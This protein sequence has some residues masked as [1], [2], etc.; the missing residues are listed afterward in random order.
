MRLGVK[1]LGLF[2]AIFSVTSYAANNN[3]VTIE[4]K[5]LVGVAESYGANVMLAPSVEFPTV[6]PAYALELGNA[7]KRNNPESFTKQFDGY[8]DPTRCY[9]YNNQG[10]YFE[11]AGQAHSFSYGG[12]TLQG[13]CYKEEWINGQRKSQYFSGSFLN[14]HTMSAID[15]LRKILTGGNR[16]EGADLLGD[17]KAQGLSE[18]QLSGH[19]NKTLLLRAAITENPLSQQSVQGPWNKS[20][21]VNLPEEVLKQFVPTDV[22]NTAKRNHNSIIVCNADEHVV[23]GTQS[24]NEYY[25]GNCEK[26]SSPLSYRLAVSVCADSS[27]QNNP[28]CKLYPNGNYKPVGIMQ[29]D[30]YANMRFALVSYL[31]LSPLKR[32]NLEQPREP[33]MLAPEGRGYKYCASVSFGRCWGHHGY[34]KERFEADKRAYENA[35]REYKRKLPQ[36]QALLSQYQILQGYSAYA[37]QRKSVLRAPMRFVNKGWQGQAGTKPEID[38]KT[39][40]FTKDPDGVTKERFSVR[41]SG[42]I[43]GLNQFGYNSAYISLDPVG[44]LVYLGMRYLRGKPAVFLDAPAV[45]HTLDGF[46]FFGKNLGNGDKFP[47]W[48]DPLKSD[49]P[50]NTSNAETNHKNKRE[51]MC[52]ANAMIVFGDTNTHQDVQIPGYPNSTITDD[53]ELNVCTEMEKIFK[54]EH[55]QAE[56]TTNFGANRSPMGAAAMAFWAN[57]RDVR[58]D[59]EGTQMIKSYFVDTVENSGFRIYGGVNKNPFYYAGKYGTFTDS[60][61]NNLPNERAEWTEDAEGQSSISDF[62]AGVPFG[63]STASDPKKMRES[64]ENIFARISSGQDFTTQAATTVSQ[65]SGETVELKDDPLFFE[66]KFNGNYWTGDVSAHKHNDQGLGLQNSEV[67]SVQKKLDA[68]YFN[69]TTF[70]SRKIFTKDGDFSAVSAKDLGLT[71]SNGDRAALIAYVQGNKKHGVQ[72]EGKAMRVRKSLLGT[73]VNSSATAILPIDAQHKQLQGCSFEERASTRKSVVAFA[74]NDGMLHIVDENGAE[75]AA[76]IPKSVL[77]LLK[78]YAAADYQHLYLHDITP[79]VY[80]VCLNNKATSLLVGATGRGKAKTIYALDVTSTDTFSKTNVKWELQDN[81]LGEITEHPVLVN[82]ADGK[83]VIITSSGYNTD[84]GKNY[85]LFID[86]NN[87]QIKEKV[88]IN[89]NTNGLSPVHVHLNEQNKA[90]YIFVG[91]YEGKVWQ[92]DAKGTSTS[93][94]VNWQVSYGNKPVFTPKS[95]KARAIY[96]APNTQKVDEKIFLSFGTG[97][98]LQSSDINASVQNYAYGMFLGENPIQDNASTIIE[99]SFTT[100]EVLI[101]EQGEIKRELYQVT[102]NPSDTAEKTAWRVQLLPGQQI[103]AMP[104]IIKDKAVHFTAIREDISSVSCTASGNTADIVVD[105]KTGGQINRAVFD[106]NQ[107]GVIDEKDKVGGML[108]RRGII[109][110]KTGVAKILDK[111]GKSS[112][113]SF[114]GKNELRIYD[115]DE[116]LNKAI[117]IRVSSRTIN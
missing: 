100:H 17:L 109:I 50:T 23:F 65:R 45:S 15:I 83:P 19:R 54:L 9:T 44:E 107:D 8:F 75:V 110:P 104:V 92:L 1:G 112:L 13:G 16:I 26:N 95:G 82:N 98:Y 64:F 86:P 76:Y 4:N 21:S 46:P 58:S 3:K 28:D 61:D 18:P 35:L 52:R 53:A 81:A 41:S 47:D 30:E 56:C 2:F 99:Q 71:N 87:G 106:T 39:G 11:S 20:G 7:N 24:R 31:S 90:Q 55:L 85:V 29:K 36:H 5:P 114:A 10:K 60:D 38:P 103:T 40:E 88:K 108:E 96:A 22:V 63:Y 97:S 27:A 116:P 115:F 93:N 62:S 12:R 70:S 113:A 89:S 79:V 34:K 6:G 84:D 72:L 77:P 25:V 51:Q 78:D 102:R 91:D 67:W 57:T 32:P 48:D 101:T 74:A 33:Y 59:L 80:D 66:S 14:R 69:E 111:E 105:L 94:G 42:V 49:F 37:G 43:N 73:V 68:Q 117:L